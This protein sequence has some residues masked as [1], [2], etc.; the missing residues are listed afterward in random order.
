MQHY[1]LQQDLYLLEF[2]QQLK[3]GLMSTII[4]FVSQKGGVGKSTLS[5]ALAREAAE[6]GL[7]VKIAD[8]DTQ[9]GTSVNWHRRRLDANLTPVFSVEPFRTAKQ[10]IS[11][12]GSYD[13]FILDGPARTSAGTLDIANAADLIVQP[14]GASLDDLEPAILVFHELIKQK[15]PR[16]KLAFALCRVGTASEEAECRAYIEQ[17]RYQTLDGC[18]FEK[19][20]YRQAQNQGQAITETRF[21]SLNKKAET[22]IQSLIDL[23]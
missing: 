4:G 10:A 1:F 11:Q 9:Q 3:R 18:L 8:L 17:A 20:A 16:E 6:S 13:L 14:T 15:V 19:P 23:I 7:S 2:M 12:A 5:R 22:L 21:S